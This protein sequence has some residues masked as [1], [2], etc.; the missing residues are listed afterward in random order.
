MVRLELQEGKNTERLEH[1]R[2]N[3]GK[4]VTVIKKDGVTVAGILIDITS[5]E[6]L[7]IRGKYK[8]AIFHFEQIQDFAAREDRFSSNGGDSHRH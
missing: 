5:D 7:V 8:N 3:I 4:F 1:Y 6:H 2:A